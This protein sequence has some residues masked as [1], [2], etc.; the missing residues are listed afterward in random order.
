MYDKKLTLIAV[1]TISVLVCLFRTT[2]GPAHGA[3]GRI[4]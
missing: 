3:N 2:S 1:K 4:M